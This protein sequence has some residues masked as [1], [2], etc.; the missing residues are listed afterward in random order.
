MIG[1]T[2][3]IDL[4]LLLSHALTTIPACLGTYDGMNVKS[5]KSKLMYELEKAVSDGDIVVIP[6]HEG[7]AALTVDGMA[8]LQTMATAADT[9]GC[10][11]KK[12]LESLLNIGRHYKCNRIDFVTDTYLTVSSKNC[13]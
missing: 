10:F 1:Q 8:M 11:A 3:K 9:F 13:D 12:M 6:S 5:D 4:K 7:D 2:R